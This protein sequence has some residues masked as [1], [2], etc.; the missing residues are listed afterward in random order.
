M[1]LLKRIKLRCR[2]IINLQEVMVSIASTPFVATV[3]CGN[4]LICQ[5]ED[6][7]ASCADDNVLHFGT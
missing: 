6:L 1:F 7:V 5:C 2:V 3:C 4:R